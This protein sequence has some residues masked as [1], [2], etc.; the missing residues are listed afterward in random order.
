[1]TIQLPRFDL[2]G[3]YKV[4]WGAMNR[5]TRVDRPAGMKSDDQRSSPEQLL[6]RSQVDAAA[7]RDRVPPHTRLVGK[8]CFACGAIN[9]L[10]FQFCDMCGTSLK[11]AAAMIPAPPDQ[12]EHLA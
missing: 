9:D 2:A 12:P 1:M 11:R 7:N 6:T 4:W 8:Q 3:S 10:S 5:R